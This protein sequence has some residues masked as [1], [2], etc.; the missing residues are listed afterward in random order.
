MQLA[1]TK[2]RHL[3]LRLDCPLPLAQPL[4]PEDLADKVSLHQGQGDLETYRGSSFPQRWKNRNS[5]TLS[6]GASSRNNK[7]LYLLLGVCQLPYIRLKI[8]S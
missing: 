5:Y 8:S 2:T 1:G 6:Q 7:L 4:L 3:D